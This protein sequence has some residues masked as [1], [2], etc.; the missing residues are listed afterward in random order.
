MI[1]LLIALSLLSDILVIYSLVCTFPEA[2]AD[3][4]CTRQ[5]KFISA[6]MPS[7]RCDGHVPGIDNLRIIPSAVINI[8]LSERRA[9][10][11]EIEEIVFSL[12]CFFFGNGYLVVPLKMDI[13]PYFP[14]L[15]SVSRHIL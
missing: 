12:I 15:Q 5:F 13:I 11:T 8:D 2:D 6:F 7:C 14:F 1:Y 3:V 10:D 9:P 4:R